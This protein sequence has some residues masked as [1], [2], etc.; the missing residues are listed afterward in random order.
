R[1]SAPA[2]DDLDG[3]DGGDRSESLDRLSRLHRQGVLS[4]AEFAEA[5]QKVL[6]GA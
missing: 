1:G 5:K 2:P 4:D 6:D 3:E